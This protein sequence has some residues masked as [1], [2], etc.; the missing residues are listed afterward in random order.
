MWTAKLSNF[1]GATSQ[2]VDQ[3]TIDKTQAG[4]DLCENGSDCVLIRSLISAPCGEDR[5][6]INSGQCPAIDSCS[7]LRGFKGPLTTTGVCKVQT[8]IKSGFVAIS[9]C[10]SGKQ[11]IG[12]LSACGRSIS[13]KFKIGNHD[14]VCSDK[15]ILMGLNIVPE[16]EDAGG[17]GKT[18]FAWMHCTDC[19][20][21]YYGS[22]AVLW[23]V[24]VT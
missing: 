12:L 7:Q 23:Y 18:A 11:T 16:D 9:R 21:W 13:A 20:L 24:R 14:R 15:A 19:I 1:G 17:R 3:P 2:C 5:R 8:C 6:I 10:N 22:M 4:I